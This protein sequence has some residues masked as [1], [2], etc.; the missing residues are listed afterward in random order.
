MIG[1]NFRKV[2]LP[3]LAIISLH[4]KCTVLTEPRCPRFEF[5]ERLLEKLIR[6]EVAMEQMKD[7]TSATGNRLE[8]C[9]NEVDRLTLD[10]NHTKEQLRVPTILFKATKVSNKIPNQGQ[11]IVFKETLSNFGNGYDSNT[12]IF[13]APVSGSYLFTVHL[14][15]EPG[16]Y[17]VSNLVNDGKTQTTDSNYDKEG[18]VCNT[19]EAIVYLEVSSKVWVEMFA[20][21]NK[22]REDGHRFSYFSGVLLHR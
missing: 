18:K 7:Q 19:S 9:M 4:C 13:D 15:S 12:G 20:A 5:E 21:G 22:I 1:M 11:I 17:I 3:I 14:C 8:H 2:L 16:G 10:L 6:L